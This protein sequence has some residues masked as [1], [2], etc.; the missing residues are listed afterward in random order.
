MAVFGERSWGTRLGGSGGGSS[1]P[2][3]G[4]LVGQVP[5]LRKDIDLHSG[6]IGVGPER[7]EVVANLVAGIRQ[8]P[9]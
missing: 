6:V 1:F 4:D 9:R 8:V 2:A 5:D 3:F 7:V